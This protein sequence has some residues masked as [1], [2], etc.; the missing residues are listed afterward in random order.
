VQKGV[1]AN[2]EQGEIALAAGAIVLIQPERV[3]PILEL[4]I[5]RAIRAGAAVFA[6]VADARTKRRGHLKVV[7]G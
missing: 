2:S 3:L 4:A 6:L 5:A 7:E 1:V